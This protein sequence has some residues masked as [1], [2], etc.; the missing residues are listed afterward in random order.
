MNEII[1]TFLVAL[2]FAL[3]ELC[4]R[5]SFIAKNR[6]IKEQQALINLLRNENQEL[7]AR[8]KQRDAARIFWLFGKGKLTPLEFRELGPKGSVRKV[9]EETLVESIFREYPNFG[10]DFIESGWQHTLDGQIEVWWQF[11]AQEKV[12]KKND[13][14]QSNYLQ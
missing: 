9:V 3:C 13:Y 1:A 11:K 10:R 6:K 14:D 4:Y 5:R 8:I 12:L 2:A 7:N